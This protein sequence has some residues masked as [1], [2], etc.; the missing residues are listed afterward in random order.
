MRQ[1]LRKHNP[2]RKQKIDPRDLPLSIAEAT[3]IKETALKWPGGLGE[4]LI[5]CEKSKRG[6][7][8]DPEYHVFNQ[9]YVPGENVM[10]CPVMEVKRLRKQPN[11]YHL[12]LSAWRSIRNAYAEILNLTLDDAHTKYNDDLRNNPM[13]LARNMQRYIDRKNALSGSKTVAWYVLYEIVDDYGNHIPVHT[14]SHGTYANRYRY[15][16]EE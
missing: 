14:M 13:E 2:N 4:A 3:A 11:H 7:K 1:Y 5:P 16:N 12:H 6:W 10:L 8:R 15:F 9:A